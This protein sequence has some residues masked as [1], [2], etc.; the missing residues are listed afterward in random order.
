MAV[1]GFEDA[2]AEEFV[3]GGGEGDVG[4]PKKLV[5]F[6]VIRIANMDDVVS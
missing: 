2:D 1:D 6:F 3:V 5:V 4:L